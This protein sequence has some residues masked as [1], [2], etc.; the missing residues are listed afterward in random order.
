MKITYESGGV[1]IKERV[2][3]EIGSMYV[4]ESGAQVMKGDVVKF[5]RRGG[6]VKGAGRKPGENRVPCAVYI[7]PS[8]MTALREESK[9]DQ[10][11]VSALICKKLGLC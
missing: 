4:T 6:R 11:S 9:R 7:L 1:L 10:C 5:D 8:D 2:D 3:G